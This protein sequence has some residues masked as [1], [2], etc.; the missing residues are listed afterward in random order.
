MMRRGSGRRSRS[1][2]RRIIDGITGAVLVGFGIRLATE[3]R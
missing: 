1:P 2:M 3:H